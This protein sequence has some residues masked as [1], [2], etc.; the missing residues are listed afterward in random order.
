MQ[1]IYT[2]GVR[3][4]AGYGDMVLGMSD[5][6]LR[7][8]QRV[9]LAGRNPAHRGASLT[10]KLAL[11]GDPAWKQ[12]V[13]PAH[14][15]AT[16]LWRS[17]TKPDTSPFSFRQHVQLWRD[18]VQGQELDLESTGWKKPRGP[19][20]RMLLCLHRIG[21]KAVGFS[22]WHDERGYVIDLLYTSPALLN[23]L[24]EEGVQRMHERRMA[25]A[26]PHFASS[27]VSPDPLRRRLRSKKLDGRQKYWLSACFSGACWTADRLKSSGYVSDGACPLC[28]EPDSIVHRQFICSD[29]TVEAARREHLSDEEIQAARH[30]SPDKL[31]F[32]SRL[33]VAQPEAPH[34]CL[35]LDPLLQG[36]SGEP[37]SIEEFCD[38][39]VNTRI[40]V[41]G[42]ATQLVFREL[43][44]ATYAAVFFDSSSETPYEVRA[45]L[46]G[47][48]WPG[49]PQT[50]QAGEHLGAA[51]LSCVATGLCEA[52]SDCLGAVTLANARPS[53]QLDPG[54]VFAG[55]RRRALQEPGQLC[56][57]SFAHTPA[58]RSDEVIAALPAQE[59][60]IALGNQDA[61]R[62]AKH[63]LS[64][65]PSLS[66]EVLEQLD[67]DVALLRK[68]VAMFGAVFSL[69]PKL[70]FRRDPAAPRVKSRALRA[71]EWHDWVVLD[72]GDDETPSAARCSKCFKTTFGD[73]R[74]MDGCPPS[75][76]RCRE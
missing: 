56:I 33:I 9:L 20:H 29:P 42:S 44:R 37:L 55:L 46:L 73:S 71:I 54:Q 12:S 53:S 22:V 51:T 50:P 24:L 26:T 68:L 47:T 32:W 3:P 75:V 10:A 5:A 30:C 35:D 58:H 14:Q 61:D 2:A 27:R 65:H 59:R 7:S 18:V 43:N 38:R 11:H 45:R 48:V 64:L 4:A 66:N 74:P 41:D 8:L 72:P 25:S 16:S 49:L 15:W 23:K 40:V 28:G 70:E 57:D 62:L 67:K 13:A 1:K 60:K 21:W 39:T 36:P 19:I 34:P 31:L 69:F 63:A 6:E 76:E 52:H 17:I